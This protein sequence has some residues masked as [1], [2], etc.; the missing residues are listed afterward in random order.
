M[1]SNLR[2]RVCGPF[3]CV[4]IA[5]ALFLSGAVQAETPGLGIGYGLAL[6]YGYGVAPRE[7]QRGR[8]VQD[9]Q[10][11]AIEPYLRLP[12]HSFGDGQRWYHGQLEGLLQATILVEL[13]PRSGTAAGGVV[14]LR[15]LLRPGARL[16]PYAEGGLGVG[17]LDFN[18]SGQDDGVSF[19]IHTAL[20]VR[21]PL[22]ER[23]ALI[24]SFLWQHVSNANSHPP[25]LGIDTVGFRIGLELW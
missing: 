7:K 4:W 20:G 15:Y 19:F 1:S 14:G 24:A 6:G 10:T 13:E 11:L 25:N 8:D 22:D 16:R 17:D 12:L 5:L 21:Y 18:L 3:G 2:R 23:F 9:V